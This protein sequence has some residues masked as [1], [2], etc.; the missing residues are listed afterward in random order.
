MVGEETDMAKFQC[1]S[2][3]VRPVLVLQDYIPI[4]LEWE[5]KREIVKYLEYGDG[6]KSLLEITVGAESKKLHR[7]TLPLCNNY[8]LKKAAEFLE[9]RVPNDAELAVT[10]DGDREV[11]KCEL[12]L[13]MYNKEINIFLS[14]APLEIC[15]FIKNGRIRFGLDNHDCLKEID[16]VDLSYEEKKHIIQELE[17]Q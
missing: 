12:S 10:I 7:I 6:S 17:L 8:T 14:K 5:R 2:E 9:N 13:V 3:F 16:I 15:K 4:R 1:C 11:K